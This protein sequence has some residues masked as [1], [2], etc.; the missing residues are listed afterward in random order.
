MNDTGTLKEYLKLSDGCRLAKRPHTPTA[1]AARPLAAA[2]Y[3]ANVTQDAA[4]SRASTGAPTLPKDNMVAS[5]PGA[6]ALTE[7]ANLAGVD[8]T[9]SVTEASPSA[10][11][12]PLAPVDKAATISSKDIDSDDSSQPPPDPPTSTA[13]TRSVH[14]DDTTDE[15]DAPAADG[16]PD[17]S[18]D[19]NNEDY[20]NDDED[21]NTDWTAIYILEQQAYLDGGYVATEATPLPRQGLRRPPS[22]QCWPAF[23]RRN[24]IGY[25]LASSLA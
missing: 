22:Q 1:A 2:T 5:L 18:D 11:A 10:T 16:G 21:D 7:P 24:R 19:S 15:E 13:R 12:T 25:P 9:Q 23:L 6:G 17:D 4:T 3:L 14:F 20:Y 8:A